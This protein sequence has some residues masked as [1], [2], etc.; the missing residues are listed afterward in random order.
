MKKESGKS[1]SVTAAESSGVTAAESNGVT[2][3]VSNGVTAAKSNGVTAAVLVRICRANSGDSTDEIH[4]E[5]TSKKVSAAQSRFK[6]VSLQSECLKLG[7]SL[8]GQED[9]CREEEDK[10]LASPPSPPRPALTVTKSILTL[11]FCVFIVWSLQ[12]KFGEAG[13]SNRVRFQ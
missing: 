1:K 6:A 7:S 8:K 11:V 2:A 13:F 3:A 12:C 10:P 4:S 5:Q 9:S